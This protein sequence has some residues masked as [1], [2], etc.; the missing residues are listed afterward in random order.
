MEKKQIS[1]QI[2]A[3]IAELIE[4]LKEQLGANTTAAV[5]R[6][7]LKVTKLAADQAK[8]HGGIVSFK[9][10]GDEDKDGILVS[11]RT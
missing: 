1:I 8:N 4:E 10:R 9:G 3:E 11:L 5:F 6:K 7:S 2:D